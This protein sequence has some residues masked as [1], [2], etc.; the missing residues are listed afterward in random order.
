MTFS[1]GIFTIISSVKA[2]IRAPRLAIVLVVTISLGA[3][4]NAAIYGFIQGLVH[5]TTPI[6]A[7]DRVG[8]IFS[9]NLLSDAGPLSNRDYERLK[10]R[11]HTFNWVEGARIAPKDI[12]LS[13]HS[14]IAT[15]A[16][17]TPDLA[18]ALGLTFNGGI[19]VS[20]HFW[21][22]TLE[23]RATVQE[24]R[25]HLNDGM[26]LPIKGIAAKELE[27]LYRDQPVDLW[28]PI[29]DETS[30]GKDKSKRDLWVLGSLRTGVSI[31]EA[32]KDV[33]STLGSP[34]NFQVI[35]FTGTQPRMTRG[36][37]RIGTILNLAAGA[38]F[39][40][41][42]TN[43]SSFLLGRALK[44]SYET[45]LRVA[46]GATRAELIWQLL[47]DSAVISITGGTFGML[48]AVCTV[49]VVP[50]LL[51]EEDAER[52]VFVPHFIPLL[53]VSTVCVAI[54]TICGMTPVVATITDR[55]WT[56]LKSESGSPS[57]KMACFRSALVIGQISMCCVLV[58]FT[59]VLIE[60]LHS[61][62]K[63]SAGQSLGDPILATVQAQAQTEV[64][65]RYFENVMRSATLPPIVSSLAWTSR[66]PGNEPIWRYFRIQPLSSPTRGGN[67]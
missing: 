29:E 23:G 20:Y 51:F 45:S 2:F 57:K 26:V 54:T 14:E 9:Q 19:V 1:H 31:D 43:V 4:S 59:G 41:A 11:Q 34:G 10:T 6:K 64:D 37:A 18:Q 55:P 39:L 66:L 27:G 7:A 52:L 48:L 3:G 17:V 28:M 21:Q 25:I 67:V 44:R 22:T 65:P 58:I 36:L 53:L 15:I 12:R 30:Q 60:S 32:K 56:V 16:A 38:V 61:A 46:L 8:S 63:T 50:A 40:I 49:H 35:H 33:C 62:L 24:D 47:S 5:P 13:N 42:V